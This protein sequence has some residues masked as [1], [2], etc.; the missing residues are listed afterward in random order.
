MGD[1]ISP[2]EFLVV[3]KGMLAGQHAFG[4]GANGDTVT[5]L[6]ADL[7]IISQ[8]TYGPNEAEISY[9]RK[10]DGPTGAW[11]AD[12]IPTIGLANK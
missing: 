12:C 2:G 10:P 4:L 3:A 7:K 9:C 11:A 6:D 5:L 8:V 1:S